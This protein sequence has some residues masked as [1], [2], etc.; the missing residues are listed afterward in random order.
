[1]ASPDEDA[2]GAKDEA[3]DRYCGYAGREEKGWDA[4]RDAKDEL[5]G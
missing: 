3:G 4:S 1:M 2:E 5:T